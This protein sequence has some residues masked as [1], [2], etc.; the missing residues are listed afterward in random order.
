MTLTSVSELRIRIRIVLL[1]LQ[2]YVLL[3]SHLSTEKSKYI[4]VQLKNCIYQK[5]SKVVT[6]E[7]ENY[8]QT[9]K[10]VHNFTAENNCIFRSY[11]FVLTNLVG[12][13][14]S[15]NQK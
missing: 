11:V 14:S 12:C 7:N 15:T 2:E 3:T 8:I 9:A 5:F 4:S 10:D 6:E 1:R 13:T